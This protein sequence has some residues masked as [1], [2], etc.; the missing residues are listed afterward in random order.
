MQIRGA[1]LVFLT[2]IILAST[3]AALAAKG[4]NKG[5]NGGGKGGGKGGGGGGD[6]GSGGSP[7]VLHLEGAGDSIMQGYNASC[8]GNTSFWDSLCLL[9]EEQPA[10]SFLDGSSSSVVSLLDRY[11]TID[12][13]W[14]GSKAASQS[15]SE[16]TDPAKNNFENQSLAI[17]SSVT[18]P[19]RVVIELG[20]NDICNRGLADEFYDDPTWQAAVDAGLDV[21]VNGLP[22]GSTVFLASVPRVQDLRQAGLIL[23][24]SDSGVDCQGVWSSFN[25]CPIATL[26][27]P[28][29][30]VAIGERQQ[31][32]NEILA[33]RAQHYNLDATSTG[34][35][36]V[37]E[38]QGESVVSVGTY[39]FGAE[40][41]NGGDCF[42]PSIQGQNKLSDLLFRAP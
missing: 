28:A 5:G 16:M 9:G 42:H 7:V 20:G 41:I 39:S 33:E 35:E 10:N 34:V 32:Y 30:L 25:V 38:Y 1:L 4:G 22:D 6:G 27:D 3:G 21:L 29:T 8:T 2:A 24:S 15:G 12:S 37:A 18:T 14:T 36:V 17:V 13:G 23:E 31:R 40:D 19:T 11:Q 26:S